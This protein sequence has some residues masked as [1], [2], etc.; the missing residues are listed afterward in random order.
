MIRLLPDQTHVA[1]SGLSADVEILDLN[2][3]KVRLY[4]DIISEN[5]YTHIIMQITHRSTDAEDWIKCLDIGK[6]GGVESTLNNSKKFSQITSNAILILYN[7]IA[8]ILLY[9]IT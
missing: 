3:L 1:V 2:S 6:L 8:I 4:Y 9:V 7:T 5:Y